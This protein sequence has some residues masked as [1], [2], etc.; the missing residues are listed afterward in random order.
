MSQLKKKVGDGDHLGTQLPTPG[1][2][3]SLQPLAILDRKMVKRGNH[4]ATMV[5]V[6]WANYFPE[7]ATWEFLYDL[8]LCFPYFQP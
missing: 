8:Q 2:S 3:I 6:H 4:A 1:V 5:L 7:D